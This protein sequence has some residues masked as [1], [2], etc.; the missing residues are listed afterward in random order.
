MLIRLFKKK[1][2]VISEGLG[3]AAKTNGGLAPHT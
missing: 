2:K 1:K 3:R